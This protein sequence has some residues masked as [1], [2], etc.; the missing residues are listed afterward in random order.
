M[1]ALGVVLCMAAAVLAATS[2]AA[3][4]QPGAPKAGVVRIMSYNVHHC[5]G[6]D[7]K[8]DVKRVADRIR[9]ENPDFACINE[10]KPAQ[11][12]ELGEKAGMYAVPCGMRSFNAIL[13]RRPPTRIEEVA[14]R[15]RTYGP[16]SL[17]ICE[18]PEFAVGVMHFEYG[19]EVLKHRVDSAAVV[20]D[21]LR[22]YGKP[23]FIAG[24]W[25]SE[26]QSEPVNVLRRSV[27]ILSNE[28]VRTWHGF[29][30]HKTMQPGKKEYCI[31]YI[32]VNSAF[33]DRVSVIETHVVKDDEASDHYPVMA[34]LRI[35]PAG[36]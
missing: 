20:C 36:N 4:R 33:A 2:C 13:S 25:N 32:S 5:E 18:Y 17:M 29:G 1:K 8:V 15:W 31:D 12:L 7:N 3:Q 24:D 14:L 11:A 30:L 28:H 6:A 27:K 19:P 16:R 35:S 10:I 9:A 34:T 26:P 21:T 23:V 22:K